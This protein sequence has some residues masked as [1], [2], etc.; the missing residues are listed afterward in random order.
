MVSVVEPV[1]SVV[2][3]TEESFL[4]DENVVA[5]SNARE[6]IIPAKGALI[7]FIS[8]TAF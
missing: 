7:F 3:T 6:H 8:I 2:G 5:V 4:Q 1:T